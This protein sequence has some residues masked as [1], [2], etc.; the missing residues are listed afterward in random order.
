MQV[1]VEGRGNEAVEVDDNEGGG[2]VLRYDN[3]TRAEPKGAAT[4]LRK[5][6]GTPESRGRVR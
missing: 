3:K 4:R 6:T 1:G 5:T 2:N